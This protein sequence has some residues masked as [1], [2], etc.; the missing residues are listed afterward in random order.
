MTL[1]EAL[2]TTR[3]HRVAGLTGDRSS[4]AWSGMGHVW[5]YFPQLAH[6]HE[7]LPREFQALGT[8]GS[9]HYPRTTRG[10]HPIMSPG[11]MRRE[12]MAGVM[13]TIVRG[14]MSPR[15]AARSSFVGP[16]HAPRATVGKGGCG[17]APVCV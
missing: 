7:D 4:L 16:R 13:S 2:E 3:I 5:P 17:I 9:E 15:R 1:T 10:Q 6:P 12:E 8:P 11:T 14:I